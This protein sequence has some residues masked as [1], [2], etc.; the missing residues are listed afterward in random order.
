MC[1]DKHLDEFLT[2][3]LLNFKFSG[4]GDVPGV[5]DEILNEAGEPIAR[6]V[7]AKLAVPLIDEIENACAVLKCSK[8]E[9]IEHSVISFLKRFDELS[10][11]YDVFEPHLVKEKSE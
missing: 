10:D 2:H 8:R 7:C 11:E 3:K 9:I 1:E 5:M 4:L 6:N